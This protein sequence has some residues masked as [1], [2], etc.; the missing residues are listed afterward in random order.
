MNQIKV[1]YIIEER[2]PPEYQKRFPERV[3]IIFESDQ[4]KAAYSQSHKG[5]KER[6][7][8]FV[9]IKKFEPERSASRL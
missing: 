5:V 2:Y 9:D 4:K 3:L 7:G 8:I 1:K 6:R